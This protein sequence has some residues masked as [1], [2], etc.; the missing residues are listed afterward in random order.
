VPATWNEAFEA[1][2]AVKAGSSVA[3]IA[4]DLVDCETMYATKKLVTSMGS[5]MLEGRQTGLSYDVSN[6]AA[7][8]FNTTIA[9]IQ[10]AD[11][12]ILVST[13]TRWEAS[14]VN[15]RIRKAVRK[16]GAKVFGI[17]PEADQTYPVE[18]LGDD[19]GLLSKLPKEAADALKNAEKPAIILGGGALS[20]EGAHG[21]ALKLAAKYKLISY[22]CKCDNVI[23]VGAACTG[24]VRRSQSSE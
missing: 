21:A 23:H 16:G 20:V 22:D 10:D 6:L 24:C 9:G 14:L 11:V 18:W 8:N 17:G 5:D 12:I 4:G 2:A 1:I 19:M 7:V 13:N 3:A 15:T